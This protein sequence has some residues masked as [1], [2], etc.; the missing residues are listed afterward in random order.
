MLIKDFMTPN[1]I[2]VDESIPVLD[3]AELMKRNR[4]RRFSV[5]QNNKLV[6]ILPTVMFVQQV[7]L[8]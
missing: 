7:L 8:G 4:V 6:G 5:M 3:A 2:T 1:P